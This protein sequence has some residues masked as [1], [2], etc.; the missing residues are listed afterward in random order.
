MNIMSYQGPRGTDPATK[1]LSKL[2]CSSSELQHQWW[3][4]QENSFHCCAT[5]TAFSNCICDFPES[6]VEGHSLY[7]ND[8]LWP[9]F[10]KLDKSIHFKQPDRQM[11]HQFNAFFAQSML[12]FDQLSIVQPIIIS[13][14]HLALCPQ[15]L[16]NCSGFRSTFFWNLPWPEDVNRIYVPFVSEIALGLLHAQGLGFTSTEAASN[17]LAFVAKIMPNYRVDIPG[18]KIENMHEPEHSISIQ[19][20]PFDCGSSRN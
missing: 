16:Y 4:M 8:F 12:G 18:R 2:F 19:F 14:F 7:C 3:F 20:D 11:F 5:A 1:S 13:G 9:V 6:V 10:H 17:F 15:L